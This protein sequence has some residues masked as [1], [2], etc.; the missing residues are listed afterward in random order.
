[1]TLTKVTWR[2]ILVEAAGVEPA[3]ENASPGASP[4][5]VRYLISLHALERTQLHVRSFISY[6]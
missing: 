3:S 4:S 5:A 2:S 6:K 1:M